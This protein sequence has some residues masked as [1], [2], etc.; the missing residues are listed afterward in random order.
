M[1]TKSLWSKFLSAL[2]IASVMLIVVAPMA[3]AEDTVAKPV[4]VLG[5]RLHPP[6]IP[7]TDVIKPSV[8]YNTLPKPV[9]LAEATT[10]Y[11]AQPYYSPGSG[12]IKTVTQWSNGI[13]LYPNATACNNFNDK[14]W[15]VKDNKPPK[16]DIWSDWYGGWGPFAVDDGYF[17]AKNT[18]FSMERTIGPGTIKDN[19]YSIKIASTEPYA[20]GFASPM[21]T[22]PPG[23]NVTVTVKYLLWDYV[24]TD[25]ANNK[26]MDWAS[27]GLKPDAAAAD[28]IYVNGYVR[29]EWNAMS[30]SFV[31][32]PSGKIMVLLQGESMGN[33]NSNIYFDDVQIEVD[34]A[35]L[36]A[37]VYQ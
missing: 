21:I 22:V 36:G 32:G 13:T 20:G 15:A 30:G 19:G 16:S 27:M 26:I 25:K 37:C 33:V 18:T 6:A 1:S 24:Q 34:G 8:I 5:P 2:L 23:S 17:Q 11:D 12:V 35:Y 10:T 4:P 9:Q 7:H 3:F 28:A 31:A 29:G 14:D